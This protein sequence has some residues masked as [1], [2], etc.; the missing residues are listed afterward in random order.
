MG[1][2]LVAKFSKFLQ[3][4]NKD[5]VKVQTDRYLCCVPRPVVPDDGTRLKQAVIMQCIF[6]FSFNFHYC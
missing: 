2:L 5:C 3:V 6:C 4:E 1:A